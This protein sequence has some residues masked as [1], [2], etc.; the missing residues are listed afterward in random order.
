MQ[1]PM[2]MEM[3]VDVSDEDI[4]SDAP[5]QF[6]DVMRRVGATLADCINN[7]RIGSPTLAGLG[8]IT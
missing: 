7:P 6:L 5:P 4:E 1:K 3:V 8:M 2:V